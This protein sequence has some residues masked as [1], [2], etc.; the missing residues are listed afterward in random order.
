MVLCLNILSRDCD[1]TLVAR[2]DMSG[3]I[4]HYHAG[5]F[6]T[7]SGFHDED[8]HNGLLWRSSDLKPQEAL[9][10][11]SVIFPFCVVRL[12]PYVR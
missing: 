6:T 9:S 10:L 7:S 12:C 11:S 4:E 2:S 3:T 8:I 5:S 1:V